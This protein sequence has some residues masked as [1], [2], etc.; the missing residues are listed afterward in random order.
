[1]KKI[2]G[3]IIVFIIWSTTGLAGSN[4]DFDTR[5]QLLEERINVLE[6]Q[7]E[8]ID[9]KVA[10]RLIISGYADAAYRVDSRK[11]IADSFDLH[12]L[13]L[14]LSQK[15]DNNWHFFSEIEFEDAPK[16]QATDPVTVHVD[17]GIDT[18]C[19]NSDDSFATINTLNSAEGK[20]YTEALNL[21]YDWRSYANFRIGRFFTPAGIW[22]IDH[23]PP[24]TATQVRPRHIRE[25]FPQTTDGIM[26]TGITALF[27][28]FFSYDAYISNG[29]GNTAHIDQNNNKAVGL[30]VEI[31]VPVFSQTTFG[32][33]IYDEILNDKTDKSATGLHFKIRQGM[34]EIQSEYAEATLDSPSIGKYQRRGYY[35]QAQ[36]HFNNWSAG[37]RYDYYSQDT[38]V[39]NAEVTR[40]LF[41]SYHISEDLSIKLEHHIINFNDTNAEDYNTTLLSLIANLSN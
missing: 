35:F 40:S 11:T 18:I 20:I 9:K 25:I 2:F 31:D 19:G 24:Y 5:V 26:L 41:S 29:E 13:S 16:F 4:K 3:I 6:D 22:S 34:K 17:C 28:H 14:F 12:H 10:N 37:L 15:I 36:H 7:N 39:D 1:M 30:R 8:F 27:D 32:V 23:Y 38:R 33:S 21:T